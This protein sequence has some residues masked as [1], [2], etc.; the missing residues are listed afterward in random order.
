R[1]VDQNINLSGG[2]QQLISLIRSLSTKKEILILDEPTSH[3]DNFRKRVLVETLN[4]M[5]DKCL[6][7][8][9]SHDEEFI[10]NCIIHKL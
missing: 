5:K 3:L 8:V 4:D 1:I 6:I 7:I 2:Q 9:V 10:N